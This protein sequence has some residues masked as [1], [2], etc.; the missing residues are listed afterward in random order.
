[1]S[2][3]LFTLFPFLFAVSFV[4]QPTPE[5]HRG[6]GGWWRMYV[7]TPTNGKTVL[8]VRTYAGDSITSV[9]MEELSKC[10]VFAP[11]SW[12]CTDDS[13]NNVTVDAD[14]LTVTLRDYRSPADDTIGAPSR[15]VAEP[16]I[17]TRVRR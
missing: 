3:L 13:G 6:K 9:R 10:V 1:M 7:A 2:R 11:D 15:R 12:S 8:R 5:Y 14:V 16:L 4:S 17:F